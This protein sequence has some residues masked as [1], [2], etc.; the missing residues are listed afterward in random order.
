MFLTGDFNAK[1]GTNIIGN[2]EEITKSGKILMQMVLQ[3]DL[4]ILNASDKCTGTWTRISGE[5]KAVL[6]YAFVMQSDEYYINNVQIDEEKLN[7]P[8]YEKRQNCIH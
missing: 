3:Q 1:I 5:E 2:K 4:T 8:K 7:T 6:D